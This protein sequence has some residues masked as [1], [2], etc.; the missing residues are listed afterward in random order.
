MKTINLYF[1]SCPNDTFITYAIIHGRI[2]LN[3]FDFHFHI[4]DIE[5]LN[6]AALSG[7]ADIVKISTALL[8][9]VNVKYFMLG[10]GAAF[11]IHGGPMLVS[12]PGKTIDKS[13]L[14]ALPGLHTTAG[15]LFKRYYNYHQNIQYVLFS[16]IFSHLLTGQ[17]DAGVIIHED[18]FTY[19]QHGLICLDDL[20][21]RWINDT[22][23][24][25]PLGV[26]VA[27]KSFD[28]EEKQSLNCIF[29]QSIQYA[30]QNYD[31]VFPWI[32]KHSQNKNPDIIKKH[33]E[34]YVNKFSLN[35][36]AVGFSAIEQLTGQNIVS[37]E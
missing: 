9:K 15:A 24:P 30:W 1:S 19:S 25:V 18:R 17:V 22:G 8:P 10:T 34:Y 6:L 31:E 37:D 2:P 5:E 11:G 3:G 26:F 21:A 36:E 14:I 23:F 32:E 35:L 27:L 13:S 29:K 20:G 12:K 28:I 16:E 33:I 7:I 4:A